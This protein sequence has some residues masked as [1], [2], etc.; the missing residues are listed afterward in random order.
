MKGKLFTLICLLLT[1][2]MAV[3]MYLT[4]SHFNAIKH[5]YNQLDPNLDNYSTGEVLFLSFERMRTAAYETD[6]PDAFPLQKEI[7]DAKVNV[8]NFKSMD[9]HSFYYNKHFSADVKLLETQSKKLGEI[10]SSM[11]PGQARQNAVLHQLDVMTPTMED[12]QEVIY[13]IQLNNFQS[14]KFL[15]TDNSGSA[16]I[17]S[18]CCLFLFFLFVAFTSYYVLTLKEVIKK[19]NMFISTIYHEFSGSIHKIQMTVDMINPRDDV[20]NTEKY[21]SKIMFHTNKLFHQTREIMEYSKIEIGNT[22]LKK[23]SFTL[24]SLMVSAVS[25]FNEKNGNC[26]VTRTHPYDGKI[27]SDMG[28]MTSI[29]H[30]FMDNA[31]KNTIK[32]TIKVYLKKTQRYVVIRV[33]DNGSGFDIK[34]LPFLFRPFNQGI[35]SETRQGIGLGLA[36]V[37]NHVKALNGKIKVRSEPGK[38]SVFTVFIPINT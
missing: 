5:Q 12:I 16:E 2:L 14:M 10:Y 35:K 13:S 6:S 26:L 21:L 24:K 19:K 36:I 11:P 30:N 20:F 34:K 31:N 9:S 18:L 37:K 32:G 8:L 22:K 7:F 28:K 38:G 17:Y 15:I 3:S 23:T 4:V 33:S 27:F 1:S 29:I 25:L